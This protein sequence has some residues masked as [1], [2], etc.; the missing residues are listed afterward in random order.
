MSSPSS[1]VR[2]EVVAGES[3]QAPR[4]HDQVPLGATTGRKKINVRVMRRADA[5]SDSYWDVF[6]IP[7]RPNMNII[8]VLMDIRETPVTADG[9]TVNP[10]AWECACLEEVCGS[11]S[12]NINGIPRQACSALVDRLP[13][14]II[15]EPFKKFPVIRDLVVDRSSMFENLKR[16]KAWVPIDG[17]YD[18]GPGPR[19]AEEERERMYELSKCMT[20]GCCLEACPQVNDHSDFIGAAAISQVRLFNHHPTGEMHASTRLDALMG[21]GGIQGC[22]KA[23]NCVRVCP[24]GIPLTDSIFEMGRAV[25]LH[26]IRKFFLG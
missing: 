7:Y 21:P 17:T 5:A 18:L 11:C 3:T 13:D 12:M 8:S 23:Q 16:V 1:P 14:P 19:M 4:Q 22:G 25:T 10:V 6:A 2:S 24:K 20:C 26:A 9:K 15:L